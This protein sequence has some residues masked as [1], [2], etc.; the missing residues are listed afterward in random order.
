MRLIDSF[1]RPP[2]ACAV[3]HTPTSKRGVID[4]ELE[5]PGQLV[6]RSHVYLCAD[7]A[8]QVAQLIVPQH[9]RA[10]TSNMVTQELAMA[11]NELS[12]MKA[13]VVEYEGIM[14]QIRGLEGSDVG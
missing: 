2:G 12:V 1:I 10:I 11:N 5:D 7:C 3:C 8:M 14:R 4:L 9:G 6:R 13:K